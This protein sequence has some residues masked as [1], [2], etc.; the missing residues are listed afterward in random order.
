VPDTAAHYTVLARRFRPQT[1]EDVVGQDRIGQA[2]RNAIRAGRVAHAY[3][4]TGARGVGKTSTARIFAKALN[5][6]NVKDAVPCNECEVC[7]SI[8]AGSDVDVLEIDGASNT[9]VDDVR[10]LRSNV[11]VRPMRSP[12]KV[13]IIDEVHMLSKSAFNALLKTLEEPPNNVKFVFCTTEPHKLPD[14]ILSRC[15]RFDFGTIAADSIM[16]RLAQ[17]A[18][19]EGVQVDEGALELVARRAAGSMRDSQSLFDQLL[20]F[21]SEHITADD[22]HQLLGTAGDDRL[23]GLFEAIVSRR[24]DVALAQLDTALEEGV[25]IGAFSDQLLH[26]LRDLM[27]IAAGADA[28]TLESVSESQRSRLAEQA[29]SWGLQTITAALEILAATKARMQRVNYDRALLELAIIRLSLLEDLDSIAALLSGADGG[30]A[31]GRAAPPP[32]AGASRTAQ[33]TAS[34]A[35][36]TTG[37]RNA[38][39]THADTKAANSSAA[40]T[41]LPAT[42]P[43]ASAS[44]IVAPPAAAETQQ[45]SPD[46]D[47]ALGGDAARGDDAGQS[48]AASSGEVSGHSS[49]AQ[50]QRTVP[51]EVASIA[52]FWA[53]VLVQAPDRLT[54]HLGKADKAAISGPNDL[55]LSFPHSYVLSRQFCERPETLGRIADL[56]SRVAGREIRVKVVA[57]DTEGRTPAPRRSVSRP[58]PPSRQKKAQLSS[59]PFV[60]QALDIFG[61]TLI[62]AREIHE[63]AAEGR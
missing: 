34:S 54:G 20:A 35:P 21:G 19:A 55:E 36:R 57:S 53:E 3:L 23:I 58:E 8:A 47:S 6:P 13:Y 50:P 44:E 11:G 62:D 56:A 16:R 60:Q 43:A 33:P 45:I 28:V 14:T 12:Y 63:T 7:Q 29:Q 59:D 42:A 52:E 51:F 18:E 49:A 30:S 39:E 27:V 1:F 10:E 32:R 2:L 15:Q 17:I 61:G 37:L 48:G 24:R 31:G 9:G 46:D 26:Y 38:V 22:V 25:Q 4:F 5:C 40:S 41:P